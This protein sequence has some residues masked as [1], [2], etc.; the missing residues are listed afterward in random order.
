MP[1]SESHS[2]EMSGPW[3]SLANILRVKGRPLSEEDVWAL[4]FAA[5]EHIEKDDSSTRITIS[6]WSLVLSGSGN[7]SFHDVYDPEAVPFR[8]PEIFQE[9]KQTSESLVYSLGMT[10]YWAAEYNVPE[11][12]PVDIGQKLHSILI[13]MCE[14]SPRRRPSTEI[15][16]QTCKEREKQATLPSSAFYIQGLVSPVLDSMCQQV[17]EFA[18]MQ[19]V[20]SQMI[21]ER[22][23]QKHEGSMLFPSTFMASSGE[24]SLPCV[25]PDKTV[26][27]FH[28]R[29]YHLSV[30]SLQSPTHRTETKEPAD[31][32]NSV[33]NQLSPF[34]AACSSGYEPQ[35][36]HV[37][38]QNS[39]LHQKKIIR[40][41][42]VLNTK[43]PPV[44][45]ELPAMIVNKKGKSYLFQ[46][47]LYVIIPSGLCLEIKCDIRSQVRTVLECAAA[48]IKLD[49]NQPHYFGLANMT[50]K[51]FFFLDED[52]LLEKVA[53]EGWSKTSKKKA[54]I[55]AFTLFFRIKYFLQNF[56]ALKHCPMIHLIYLQL[57]KDILEEQL[58][59][60]REMALHL[61]SLALQ[62]DVG[63]HSQELYKMDY[64]HTEDFLPPG[65]L[66]S[67]RAVQELEQLHQSHFG[68]TREEAELAFIQV[69][70]QL[71]EYGVLFYHVLLD[72]K[73]TR[74]GD[75][76]LGI[77]CQGIIL[78]EERMGS[79]IASLRF[80]WREIQTL[81]SYKKK[82]TVVSCSSG[83]KHSFLT[84]SKKTSKYILD[85]CSALRTFHTNLRQH[86][87]TEE[88]WMLGTE[89]IN[90]QYDAQRDQMMQR[91]SRSEDLLC[92]TN[93]NNMRG[94]ILSKSCNFINGNEKTGEDTSVCRVTKDA[95]T[96]QHSNGY[97]SIH[98]SRSASC[99][100]SFK[101]QS[102]EGAEREILC[103][104]LKRD[105]AYGLGFMIVGGE[106]IGKLDLGI[107]VASVIPGGPAERDGQIKTGGR[108]ISVNN[109]SL[110]GMTFKSAVQI[111][112]T[113]GEEA[114]F[115][116]SQ[117]KAA[118]SHIKRQISSISCEGTE[119]SSVTFG[120]HSS[121]CGAAYGSCFPCD[122]KSTG[123]YGM[124]CGTENEPREASQS[125]KPEDAIGRDSTELKPGDVFSVQ[126]KR[127]G[128]SFGFSV[129]GGVNTSVRHGGIYIKNIIPLGPANL[130]GQI[131]KG[132]C[133][134]EVNGV[135][136]LGFTHR[137]AVECIKNAG[138]LLTVVLQRGGDLENT[139][140]GSAYEF[141]E[142]TR[143][144]PSFCESSS[145]FYVSKENTFEVTLRKN[146]GG[147][148]FS[149]VQ[150]ETGASGRVDNI[151]RIKR[152]FQG[153]PAQE[154]GQI[155]AGDVLLAVNGQSTQG[156]NYKEVVH[157]LHGA[158]T[159]VTLLLCRPETGALPEIDFTAPTPMPSPVRDILRIRSP[160][161]D[162]DNAA[163]VVSERDKDSYEAIDT[164]RLPSLMHS[165]LTPSLETMT[166]LAQAVR[167]NCYS[168]CE[169]ES[170][171][172]SIDNRVGGDGLEECQIFSDEEYLTIS[173]TSITP[174]S[175]GEVLD[176]Q[177]AVYDPPQP[178]ALIPLPESCASPESS[179]SES[180]WEDLEENADAEEE[181][182]VSHGLHKEKSVPLQLRTFSPSSWYHQPTTSNRRFKVPSPTRRTHI[183]STAIRLKTHSPTRNI[184]LSS[185]T[186][187][188]SP[189]SLER[190]HFQ[191][192]L[193]PASCTLQLPLALQNCR[194][195]SETNNGVSM[196]HHKSADEAQTDL[197]TSNNT[198][199]QYSCQSTQQSE[200]KDLLYSSTCQSNDYNSALHQSIQYELNNNLKT[201]NNNFL[202]RS[203]KNK[204]HTE[205]SDKSDDLKNILLGDPP[206]QTFDK[207]PI[208][209][210]TWSDLHATENEETN[211]FQTELPHEEMPENQ[212]KNNRTQQE[213]IQ[214]KL[215][216]NTNKKQKVDLSQLDCP[217]IQNPCNCA[218]NEVFV[219]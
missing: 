178:R 202:D 136:M 176:E 3:V 104:K 32:Y 23:R 47:T 160:D 6:P 126:L 140:S 156:M 120:T 144:T 134:L 214:E 59:C 166:A 82:F 217:T 56:S 159:Q 84:N 74:R 128:G 9:P 147:L 150:T 103:V 165:T 98:S 121:S 106:N 115:I 153:L 92:F 21:R 45:L 49:Q 44:T 19:Y 46:R 170:Q 83:K 80:S 8:A 118:H 26:S 42:F 167:L 148:G 179:E 185:P 93:D 177:T 194:T 172:S 81:S 200:I 34:S 29:T 77:C 208:L 87:R 95:E 198:V 57:R 63:D 206:E 199:D 117:E 168:I 7:L 133:L 18:K 146:L 164:R 54:T 53:P 33:Q 183:S 69:A 96:H 122:P 48:Y 37:F 213:Y 125:E 13:P 135:H 188:V 107:F 143:T 169:Q 55:V 182:I 11:H 197:N 212:W 204:E 205:S 186:V 201:I 196:L 112:Q 149:F 91:M 173:S 129:T 99:N 40:P 116:L 151:I 108:L 155:A 39:H 70:Q 5:A 154:S 12:Q 114:E 100:M 60:N 27:N 210:H 17:E 152:L 215:S 203:N 50:G 10:L 171:N 75:H 73:K 97:L 1:Y 161:Y 35:F 142:S 119:R 20:Q 141:P 113:C 76:T 191:C 4:L 124:F 68:L 190:Q 61:G 219:F 67:L 90:P 137:Q 109:I 25:T 218:L 16:L 51:E 85:L 157:I 58:Y 138:E 2:K 193:D 38:G 189:P 28:D 62:A 162:L 71:P 78:Y 52:D 195:Y 123:T 30:S 216:I 72:K 15:I 64:F 181:G 36:K 22:F 158:P 139:A 94:K 207:T 127:D 131:K 175:W 43:E 65:V 130:N 187:K 145:K 41:E 101:E 31:L 24:R 132:D 79:R 111:L 110:E 163:S 102:L 86:Q 89:Y 184:T 211:H 105:P 180:E 88:M 192:F 209:E 66:E 174:P 14:K